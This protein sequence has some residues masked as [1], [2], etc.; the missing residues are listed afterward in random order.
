MQI[1]STP[2]ADALSAIEA[3]TRPM[4]EVPSWHERL[5]AAPDSRSI[6]P[7]A[8][9]RRFGLAGVSYGEPL[10]GES[11]T[12]PPESMN[13]I[14]N[15]SAAAHQLNILEYGAGR[16]K[17]VAWPKDAVM[18]SSRAIVVEAEMR[19]LGPALVL[20]LLLGHADPSPCAT[21]R[22]PQDYASITWA[23]SVAHS[24]DEILIACGTYAEWDIRV[25]GKDLTIRGSQG[26]QDCVVMDAHGQTSHIIFGDS[27]SRI[28]NIT[29]KNGARGDGAVYVGDNCRVEIVNCAFIDNTHRVGGGVYVRPVQASVFLDR[30]LIRNNYATLYGGGIGG[31]GKI[32]ATRCAF[33]G[34]RAGESGGAVYTTGIETSFIYTSSFRTNSAPAGGGIYLGSTLNVLDCTFADNAA[35]RGAG[36]MTTSGSRM[37]VYYTD[38]DDPSYDCTGATV[39][40]HCCAY[41]SWICGAVDD[42]GCSPV[43]VETTSWGNLKALYR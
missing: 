25:A 1:G 32:F 27:N 6:D 28:E 26:S 34:N 3:P 14:G 15:F 43:G 36:F 41:P 18:S 30:V 10:K 31:D 7:A 21:L 9:R 24:G 17:L 13:V 33:E 16:C 11:Q 5:T 2:D 20:V 4:W 38:F 22:V 29:F 8:T 37:Y 19:Y 23:V 12:G 39:S 40:L 42:S 35:G